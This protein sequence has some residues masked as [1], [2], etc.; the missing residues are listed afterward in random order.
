MRSGLKQRAPA[1]RAL[2]DVVDHVLLS[3]VPKRSAPM[4]VETVAKRILAEFDEMPGMSLTVHQASR[5]FG[6]DPDMCRVVVDALVDS[7][8]LRQTAGIV[9]RGDRVAA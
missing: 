8:Y 7:A 3:Q 4:N 5:L 1:A 9:R 2:D 6:L